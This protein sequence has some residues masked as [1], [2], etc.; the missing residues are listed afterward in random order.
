MCQGSPRNCYRKYPEKTA[1]LYPQYYGSVGYYALMG[2]CG[3]AVVGVGE[4]FDKRMKSV[5]RCEAADTNGA[6]Q[7]TVPVAK[8]HGIPRARWTD[9]R[10][11]THGAWWHVHRVTFESAYGRTPF[12]EY[13]IDRFMPFLGPG[14]ADD[15]PTIADLDI[16]I[17]TELRRIL[18]LETQV[19]YCTFPLGGCDSSAGF[20]DASAIPPAS[21]YEPYYQVRGAR[22]GF[23]AGMSV[24]DLIFN[25]G[26]EAPLY[27]SR[28]I[29]G[30]SL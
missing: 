1:L 8:P 28:M 23:V 25:L 30:I 5:H 29:S 9:V 7:L 13:Y 6:L 27:L 10:L 11:S 17:D 14:V 12:F 19:T 16:A 24:L 2:A 22:H 3:H 15:F 26:P 18:L 21:A 4:L 20:V